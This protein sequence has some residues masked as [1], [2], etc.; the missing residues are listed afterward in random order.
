VRLADTTS[1][2][3]VIATGVPVLVSQ[4]YTFSV[5]VRS[6]AGTAASWRATVAFYD[7]AGAIIGSATNGTAA[8]VT[9]SYVARTVTA[10]SPSTAAYAVVS[11]TN[12]A[13]LAA[14]NTIY[15][16]DLMLETGSSASAWA[17]GSGVP[18]V[19]FTALGDT[20]PLVDYHDASVTLL[21]VG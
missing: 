4:A 8:V 14:T 15:L 3:T 20:Y 16:D 12:N 17:L 6:Q 13:T 21:E 18:K 1:A 2:A 5:L 19:A 9:G 11:V 7:A 10:T